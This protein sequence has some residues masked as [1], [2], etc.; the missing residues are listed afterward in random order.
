MWKII[1]FI[2]HSDRLP[3]DV[4]SAWQRMAATPGEIGEHTPEQ[5]GHAPATAP[6]RR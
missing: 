1:A 3:P 6:Q 5:H 2:K 4:R